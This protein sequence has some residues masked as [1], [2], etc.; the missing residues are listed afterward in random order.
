MA[1][2]SLSQRVIVNINMMDI[3]RKMRKP[4]KRQS[5]ITLT[6]QS[7]LRMIPSMYPVYINPSGSQNPVASY[8]GTHQ[9]DTDIRMKSSQIEH[10]GLTTRQPVAPDPEMVTPAM[11][12]AS[13]IQ[14]QTPGK[15]SSKPFDKPSDPRAPSHRRMTGIYRP[16]GRPEI[17]NYNGVEYVKNPDGTWRRYTGKGR[18]TPS[19]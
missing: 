15:S 2:T 16:S 11:A 9:V 6:R 5:Q 10:P 13:H 19:S 8:A 17:F 18:D 1:R 12:A 7:G 3:R 4:R 14:H